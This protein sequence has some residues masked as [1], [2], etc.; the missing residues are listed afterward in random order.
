MIM[1]KA[2]CFLSLSVIGLSLFSQSKVWA[3]SLQNKEIKC[4]TQNDERVF[5]VSEKFLTFHDQ[6]LNDS[7]LPKRVISSSNPVRTKT[8][9]KGIVQTLNYEGNN[10]KIVIKD[11]NKMSEISDYLSITNQKGHEMTYPITCS[12]VE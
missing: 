7:F 10:H 9:G 2:V 3:S 5:T 11:L 1:K 4:H 8:I 6:S 12:F